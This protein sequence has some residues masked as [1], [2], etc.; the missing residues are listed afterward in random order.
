MTFALGPAV[1]APA[2]L[3]EAFGL[4]G[5]IAIILAETGLMVGF[6][7][8]GDSLLFT[9]GLLVAT[10]VLHTPLWLVIAI[11]A[12][13][14]FAGDQIGYGIGRRA[15]PAVFRR[16]DSRFF[17]QEY[18]TRSHEFFDKYGPGTIVL[19]RFVP[20]VRTFAPVIAGASAMRYRMFVAYNVI[21]GVAWAIVVTVLGYFL[22]QI[23]FVRA[24]IEFILAGIIIVS[25]LPVAVGL[26]R[27]RPGQGT[28]ST[29][30]S[31]PM[32]PRTPGAPR[33]PGE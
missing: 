11:I 29:T 13:A 18:V 5:I 25:V 24:N 31:R 19:A 10:H 30:A 14:A 3:I 28:A 9:A 21:G 27:H 23:A 1:L 4:L 15:G 7:M 33:V 2:H 12:A 17:R 26:W 8:P 20:I 32:Q 16:P 6:F 22:G